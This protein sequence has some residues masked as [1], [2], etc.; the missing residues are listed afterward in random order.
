[1]TAARV[2]G[3]VCLLVCG[4]RGASAETPSDSAAARLAEATLER[5]VFR[6]ILVG[7]IRYPSERLTWVLSRSV[8]RVQLEVFCQDGQKQPS[9]GIRLDG[10]ETSESY[11][12]PPATVRYAGKKTRDNPLRYELS[13]AA[14]TPEGSWCASAP[15]TLILD[16]KHT[17]VSMLPAGAVLIPGKKRDDDTMTPAHWKPATR[18]PV[19]GLRCELAPVDGIAAWRPAGPAKAGPPVFVA[20]APG[21]P[22]GE[23]ADENSDMVVQEGAYRQ[24]LADP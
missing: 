13:I 1:M 18:H 19:A 22:G 10:A 8:T 5:R 23:W 6:H 14:G 3:W 4:A 7:K 17:K 15:G 2:A 21:T 11:W 12:L 24:I 16:C 9:T 20:A